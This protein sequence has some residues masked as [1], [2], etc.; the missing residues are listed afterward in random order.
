MSAELGSKTRVIVSGT[1][2]V[3]RMASAMVCITSQNVL[4]Y[5]PALHAVAATAHDTPGTQ[6]CVE[7]HAAREGTA[8]LVGSM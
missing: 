2:C 6:A 7:G 5:H 1:V 8:V 3:G 4:A